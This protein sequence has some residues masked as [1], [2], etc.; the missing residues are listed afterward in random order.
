MMST[1]L[2]V[3]HSWLLH[4]RLRSFFFHYFRINKGSKEV[5]TMF[6]TVGYFPQNPRHILSAWCKV[7]NLRSGGFRI[8]QTAGRQSWRGSPTSYLAKFSQKLHEN[9]EMLGQRGHASLAPPPPQICQWYWGH[10]VLHNQFTMLGLCI[11][12]PE[13]TGLR[14]LRLTETYISYQIWFLSPL[15]P[16]RS[17]VNGSR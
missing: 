2:H 13:P 11:N 4:S 17:T 15:N 8:S 5:Y 7:F 16:N 10:W 12:S 6:L 14:T 1:P 3:P 9:E